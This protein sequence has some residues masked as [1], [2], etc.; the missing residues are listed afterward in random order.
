MV[1][2]RAAGHAALA[3]PATVDQAE[4]PEGRTDLTG[5]PPREDSQMLTWIAQDWFLLEHED[6]KM[7]LDLSGYRIDA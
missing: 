5:T 2:R 3:P 1:R 4:L 7:S 6:W